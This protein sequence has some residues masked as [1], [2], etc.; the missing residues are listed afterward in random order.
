[1]GLFPREA[2]GA[3]SPS[4]ITSGKFGMERLPGNVMD[5]GDIAIKMGTL[6]HEELLTLPPGFTKDRCKWIFSMMNIIDSDSP[7]GN[8]MLTGVGRINIDVN[9]QMIMQCIL[10]YYDPSGAPM[11]TAHCSANYIMFCKKEENDE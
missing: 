1:M 5:S 7:S 9:E 6:Q 4:N 2:W 8:S 3:I 10:K 11:E